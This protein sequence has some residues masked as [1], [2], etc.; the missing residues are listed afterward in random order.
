MRIWRL[1]TGSTFIRSGT[2]QAHEQDTKDFTDRQHRI[3]RI[4]HVFRGLS[5]AANRGLLQWRI[6]LQSTK[7]KFA[8]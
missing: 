3:F 5:Q 2:D 1:T 4:L 6:V 8:R 7:R